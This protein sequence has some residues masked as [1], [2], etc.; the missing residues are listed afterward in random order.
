[1]KN[2][3]RLRY[4]PTFMLALIFLVLLS[5]CDVF[6]SRTVAQMYEE[7]PEICNDLNYL[8]T[9]SRF[10]DIVIIYSH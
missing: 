7:H 1:M 10:I 4:F 5:G 2:L 3:D 6:T 8:R 9:L